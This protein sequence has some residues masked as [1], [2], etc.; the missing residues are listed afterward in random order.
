MDKQGLKVLQVH[1][2]KLDRLASQ[3]PRASRVNKV[4]LAS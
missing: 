3:V 1:V 2:V 4:K